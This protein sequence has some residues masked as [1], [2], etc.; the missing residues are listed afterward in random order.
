[1][2]VSLWELVVL[3]GVP[4]SITGLCVWWLKRWIEAKDK[5]KEEHDEALTQILVAQVMCNNAALS[6]AE[7][8]A[9]AIARIPDTHCNGD[10]HE[11]LETA[12]KMREEQKALL[13][14]IG[15]KSAFTGG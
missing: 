15:V 7:A 12:K 10:M 6:L 11:A 3:M 14:K 9:N 2:N 5:K 4:S 8:T 13:T 1:M